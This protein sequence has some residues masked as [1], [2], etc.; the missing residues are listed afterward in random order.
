MKVNYTYVGEPLYEYCPFHAT[1]GASGADLRNTSGNFIEIYPMS[2]ESIPT[3]ICMEIPKGFE[4][5]LRPRSGIS[6]K[7][8]L[9]MLPSV[10]TIDSDYRG[11]IS[12]TYFNP[13]NHLVTIEPGERV[14]QMIIAP[15]VKCEY[16]L[17]DTLSETERGSGGFGSTGK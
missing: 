6:V 3:G 17:K 8:K 4:G 1:E 7:K 10:G 15:Y 5:Q 14:A 16:N 13:T 2:S 11:E 9:M 12:V